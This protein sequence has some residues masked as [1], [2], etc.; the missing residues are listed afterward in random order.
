MVI[1]QDASFVSHER[2]T[3]RYANGAVERF[4]A[5]FRG[6]FVAGGAEGTIR[7]RST[8]R[9]PSR[10]YPPCDSGRQRW[11]ARGPSS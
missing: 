11:S 1:Q 10:R 6:R 7:V 8:T 3:I 2:W 5:V 4:R 9:H